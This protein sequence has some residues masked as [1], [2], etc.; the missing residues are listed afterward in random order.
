MSKVFN[1]VGGGSGKNISSIIITGLKSTDTVTCTKDGKSYPAAWDEVDLQWEIVR[2][3][4]GTFTVIATNGTK[5]ITETV[6]IDI[7]GV[8]GIEMS[9]KF[10]LY[11][12]GD[13][14]EDVTGGWTSDGYTR[15]SYTILAGG[16]ESDALKIYMEY[17]TGNSE[18]LLGTAKAID[19]SG[20]S[21]ICIEYYVDATNAY[22]PS[23]EAKSTKAH[24]STVLFSAYG[25]SNYSKGQRTVLEID[26]SN[27]NASGYITWYTTLASTARAYRIWLEN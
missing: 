14:R 27:V 20:Y 10:Y 4:L 24:E 15:S 7:A 11:N 18:S 17:T 2:L 26:I 19:F 8:Y 16:K 21:K 9:L 22:N 5:T 13:E 25:N 23:L 1:M 3:P 6:L 12:E